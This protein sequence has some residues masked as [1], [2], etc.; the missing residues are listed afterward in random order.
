MGEMLRLVLLSLLFSFLPIHAGTSVEESLRK[1]EQGRRI[2]VTLNNGE[3]LVGHVGAIQSD[4]F[5]FEPDNK[6]GTA[7]ELAFNVV[8]SV[9]PAMTKTTKWMIGLGI[10]GALTGLG[11]LL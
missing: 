8:R 5:V 1:L 10:W 11:A 9:K 7:R 4:S 2:A 3:K 6:H